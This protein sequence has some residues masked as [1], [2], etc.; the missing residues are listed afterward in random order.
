MWIFIP[1]RKGFETQFL[2][3]LAFEAKMDLRER[4]R[5]ALIDIS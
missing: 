3:F 5:Q 2:N 1:F 4:G